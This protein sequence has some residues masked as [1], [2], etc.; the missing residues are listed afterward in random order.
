[1]D[2]RRDLGVQGQGLGPAYDSRPSLT[3]AQRDEIR[4]RRGE[5]ES[6][7]S[8]AAEFKVSTS[9]IRKHQ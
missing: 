8:L 2:R 7:V 5:G 9:T 6:V 1:M 3:P 4:R